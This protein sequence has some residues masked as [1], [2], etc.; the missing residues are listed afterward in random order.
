[1][2]DLEN[3]VQGLERSVS[4]LRSQVNSLKLS[5]HEVL[6]QAA[7]DGLELPELEP[8]SDISKR[9]KKRQR[10]RGAEGE[11]EEEEEEEEAKSAAEDEEMADVA[12]TGGVD[13]ATL[14]AEG[15]RRFDYSDIDESYLDPDATPAD[16]ERWR[17]EFLKVLA[18]HQA[19]LDSLAPNLKAIGQFN[20]VSEKFD[21]TKADWEEKK[22]LAK[23]AVDRF[24]TIKEQR[25]Q[26]FMA[27]YEHLSRAISATYTQLTASAEMPI[28]QINK[29]SRRATRQR[30]HH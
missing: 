3:V 4:L 17:Q 16:R 14:V 27:A 13:A 28:G 12:A 5:R 26:A 24:E 20:E 15:R 30:T 6:R 11:M 29:N 7:V 25:L 10:R 1:V 18:H 23:L 8:E 19:T 21:N 9:K 2:S 22:R